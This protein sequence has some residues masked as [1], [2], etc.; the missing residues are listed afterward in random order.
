MRS[1]R[2]PLEQ[3]RRDRILHRE[4]LFHASDLGGISGGMIHSDSAKFCS[5]DPLEIR[6]PC[7]RTDLSR[8]N[9]F[10]AAVFNL[11]EAPFLAG[12][13]L[14][15][16][17]DR[18][19]QGTGPVSFS[20]G[21]EVVVPGQWVELNFPAESFGTYGAPD[22]WKD[23]RQIELFFVREK[24]VE[25]PHTIE[26][27]VKSVDVQWREIPEGP[28]LTPEGLAA[29][30]SR[31]VPG[32]TAF[33]GP[34]S[35]NT[36][37]REHLNGSLASW[38]PYTEG[39]CGLFVPPPHSYPREGADEILSG[40][41]MGQRLLD[42]I[43]WDANPLGI[44]EWTHFLNR[45]HF[46]RE[47]VKAFAETR[48]D[49]YA[50]GVDKILS[51][52]IESSPVPLDSNGGA[53]PSWETLST[54]WRLREWLWV[55]GIV[56]PSPAFRATTRIDML[57]SIWEHATSLMDHQGHPNNWIIVESAALALA[58]LCFPQFKDAEHWWETGLQRLSDQFH[59]QFLADG[60]HFELSPL[61]HA[62]CLHAFLEVKEAVSIKGGALPKE[63]GLPLEHCAEF[64]AA[65][66]RPGFTW[67]SINDS[68]G[69]TGDF[70]AL[71]K[72]VGDL[73]SRPDFCWIGTQGRMGEPPS[74][75][76]CAFP[77]AGLAIMRSDYGPEANHLIFR[78]GPAGAAHM[79]GD[80]LSIDV[81]AYGFP[82]L[83]DP[84]VTTYA[85]DPLTDYYRSP[86]AHNIVLVDGEGPQREQLPFQKRIE[87]AGPSFAFSRDGELEIASGVC[88][89]SWGSGRDDISLLR[90]V[91]FVRRE[92]WIVRDAV[93]G[94]GIH[95]ITTCWQFFPGRVE[96]EMS[97]LIAR[98][99]DARE[100][101]FE[102]IPLHRPHETR[103][104][105]FVGA[106]NPP[107]GWVSIDGRDHPGTALRYELTAALPLAIIWVLLPF[108]G[109]VGSGVDATRLDR[110]A[111]EICIRLLFS[112]GAANL[113]SMV[114]PGDDDVRAGGHRLHGRVTF[115]EATYTNAPSK[116]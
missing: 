95:R 105:Q 3:F 38:E 94:T 53:G 24:G 80:A 54:A 51:G 61:Y 30:L 69:C 65:L 67:P 25:L 82:R 103:V 16:G 87:P 83:V 42:P 56:W 97:G 52:W 39:N 110:N 113:I 5:S 31:D 35:S 45:H 57:C 40:R 79:H 78:A 19:G 89:G 44:Q 60:A 101:G 96:V 62:I 91:V 49:R 4:T 71:L 84:G 28:R 43:P 102:L 109:R 7:R 75:T 112:G 27:L 6:L 90:T 9:L 108:R 23:I 74:E 116:K 55:V 12:L 21:R 81:S 64:L 37:D 32:V 20:G 58:G 36:A 92:Y 111:G 66:H 106:L 18:R 46:V 13:R 76:S 11:S 100:S 22:N 114:T 72:K 70:T 17:P 93:T 15:H 63:F 8:F 47:L 88:L 41:I 59:R 26:A 85:P 2:L 104:D 33:F 77:D 34:A 68:G 14:R 48:D 50:E 115:S 10:T 99:T 98:C 1:P 107:A 73:F 86:Q 29:V